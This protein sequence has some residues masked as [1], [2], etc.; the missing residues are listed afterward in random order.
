MKRIAGVQTGQRL[1]ST[2]R[3]TAQI[4]MQGQMAKTASGSRWSN[5]KRTPIASRGLPK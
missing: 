1:G 4:P 5:V 2:A 3:R